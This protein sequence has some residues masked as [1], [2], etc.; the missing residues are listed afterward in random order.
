MFDIFDIP[1]LHRRLLKINTHV[2]T[3]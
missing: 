2:Y 3:V 1:N